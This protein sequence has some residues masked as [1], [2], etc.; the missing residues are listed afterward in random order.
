MKKLFV[1]LLFLGISFVVISEVFAQVPAA[2]VMSSPAVAI[3]PAPVTSLTFFGFIKAN[4]VAI[5]LAIYA[6]LD[7]VILA[8]PSLAGNG[9]IHQILI[10][11]GKLAGQPPKSI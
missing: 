11:T 10:T 9:L 4:A 8:V 6:I 7:V 5:A 3:V 1:S 2:S